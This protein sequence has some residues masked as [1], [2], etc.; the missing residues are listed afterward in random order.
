MARTCD[1]VA[2]FAASAAHSPSIIQ[3]ARI[4][5]KGPSSAGS[6]AAVAA[7]PLRGT[8]HV[9]AGATRTST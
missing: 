2:V 1:F 8:E 4:N 7:P 6:A 5:S 3:R 9:D